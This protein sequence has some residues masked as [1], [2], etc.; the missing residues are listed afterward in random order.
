MF[1]VSFGIWVC[2]GVGLLNV[3]INDFVVLFDGSYLVVV[4]YGCG[5][6]WIS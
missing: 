3:L 4:I 1:G 6:W 2:L 5:M